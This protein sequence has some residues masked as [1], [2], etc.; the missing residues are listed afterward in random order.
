MNNT[1]SPLD[2]VIGYIRMSNTNFEQVGKKWQA[3]IT[4]N[5]TFKSEILPKKNLALWSLQRK[6]AFSKQA[7]EYI[8]S[9]KP[10]E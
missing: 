7:V 6:V 2:I 9:I 4:L 5:E 10:S 8:D 3:S 1:K